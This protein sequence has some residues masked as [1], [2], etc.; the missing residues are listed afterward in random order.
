[1]KIIDAAR[2]IFEETGFTPHSINFDTSKPVGVFSRAA[3]LTRS[4]E[5]LGWEPRT[6]FREGLQRTIE[7]YYRDRDLDEVASRLGV[8]LTER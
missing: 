3:D 7:W 6:N 8:L 5:L 2:M 1:M 4:R